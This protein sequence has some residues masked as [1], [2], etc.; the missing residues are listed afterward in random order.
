MHPPT[1][2]C[3]TPSPPP[4]LPPSQVWVKPSAEMQYLYG[5]H[6]LKSGLGR[7]A[8][9]RGRDGRAGVWRLASVL[10]CCCLHPR[11]PPSLLPAIH[12]PPPKTHAPPTPLPGSLRTPSHMPPSPTH[13]PTPPPTHTQHPPTPPPTPRTHTG[14]PRTPLPTLGWWFCPCLMCPWGLACRPSPRQSAAARVGCVCGGGGGEGRGA[15]G[16]GV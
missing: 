1:T 11:P 5:N 14:S 13:N 2:P 4:P 15:H 9:A 7:W 8:Q 12:A 16:V 10:G 3:P 6:V